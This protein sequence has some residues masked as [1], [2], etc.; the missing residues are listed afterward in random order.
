MHTVS[1]EAIRVCA[2]AVQQSM[3]GVHDR[4]LFS[5]IHL[6]EQDSLRRKGFALLLLTTIPPRHKLYE[7][8]A[9]RQ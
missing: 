5:W 8:I 7:L 9:Q 1:R 6:I 3:Q 2:A 4:S